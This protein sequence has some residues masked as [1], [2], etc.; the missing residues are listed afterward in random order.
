ME[1]S[2]PEPAALIGKPVAGTGASLPFHGA[3]AAAPLG[4]MAEKS[5]SDRTFH[6]FLWILSTS[7]GTKIITLVGQIVLARLLIPAD[8]GLV[9]LAYTVTTFTGILQRD[10]LREILVQRGLRFDQYANAAFWMSLA[11]GLI[12]AGLTLAAA[13]FAAHLYHQPELIGL[14][15]ILALSAPLQSL[16]SVPGAWLQ[17]ELRFRALSA[18]GIAEGLATS[19]LTVIFA[20]LGC[21]AYS[22]VLPLPLVQICSLVWMWRLCGFRPRRIAQWELWRELFGSSSLLLGAAALYAFNQQGASMVLGLVRDVATVGL[23]FFALNLTTQLTGFLTNNL[24][25]VLLPSLSHL[26]DDPP[27]QIEAF[28]RVTRSVNLVGMFVCFGLAAVSDPALRLVYGARWVAAIPLMQII[29]VGMAFNISFAVS[30]NLMMAQGRYRALLLFNT[31]RAAGFIAL[32]GVG[33]RL[34]GALAVSL[35]TAL[36]MIVYGPL[37][38]SLAIRPAG[39]TWRDVWSVHCRPLL[40]G[41]LPCAAAVAL[42]MAFP[43]LHRHP[44]AELLFIGTLSCLGYLPLAR[45]LAP[46]TWQ[47]LLART[48][49]LRPAG[50]VS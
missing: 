16:Q 17:K 21:K 28:L 9:A 11:T 2:A 35:A 49:R 45:R 18:Q 19:L 34:G 39:K 6:G 15:G 24:W 31:Y 36:Y 20:L 22:I 44:L 48:R 33:G 27:R 5:L 40:A 32:V 14:L 38:T 30:I 7:A 1:P 29:S 25:A 8:Y 47:E 46:D 3:D 50:A 10:G 23:Y 43:A 37:I 41:A 26:Q 4:G 12:A 42:A 13:T